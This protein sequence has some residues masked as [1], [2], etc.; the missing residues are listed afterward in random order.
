MLY[1]MFRPEVDEWGKRSELSCAKILSL[2]K[3]DPD[4]SGG[5]DGQP[6]VQNKDGEPQHSVSEG[7][8]GEQMSLEEYEAAL[9]DDHT[10]D[11]VDLDFTQQGQTEAT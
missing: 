8:E 2:R 6:T 7:R 4:A 10:F 3:K 9:D 5:N 11:D 1:T